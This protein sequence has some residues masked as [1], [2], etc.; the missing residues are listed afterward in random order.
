M[1]NIN[2]LQDDIKKKIIYNKEYYGLYR[3]EKIHY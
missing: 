3:N 1:N 2:L